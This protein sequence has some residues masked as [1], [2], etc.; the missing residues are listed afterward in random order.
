MLFSHRIYA[1]YSYYLF[2][3]IQK[4]LNLQSP[5][6]PVGKHAQNMLRVGTPY[7]CWNGRKLIGKSAL[8][9]NLGEDPAEEQSGRESNGLRGT[10]LIT[11]ISTW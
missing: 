3:L 1:F 9:G 4:L 6:I 10:G 2:I 7:N 8:L 5:G 11:L